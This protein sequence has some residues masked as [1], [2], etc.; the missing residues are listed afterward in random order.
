VEE[1]TLLSSDGRKVGTYVILA[2]K[3]SPPL[4]KHDVG[5]D[6]V[7]PGKF[8]EAELAG[9]IPVREEG[10]YTLLA[11]TFETRVRVKSCH[12]LPEG[13]VFFQIKVSAA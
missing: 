13:S 8:L 5:E 2:K 7:F 6:I 11:A 4:T 3:S 10:P 1:A 12:P 9:E